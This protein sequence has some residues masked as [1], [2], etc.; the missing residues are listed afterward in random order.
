MREWWELQSLEHFIWNCTMLCFPCRFRLLLNRS[1]AT[2]VHRAW[3]AKGLRNDAIGNLCGTR[4][5]SLWWKKGSAMLLRV[6]F[7]TVVLLV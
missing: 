7:L 3:I 1:L 6:L 2:Q 4:G 5:H